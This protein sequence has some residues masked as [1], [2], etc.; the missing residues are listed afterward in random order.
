MTPSIFTVPFTTPII[1]IILMHIMT[2]MI[3]MIGIDG[4]ENDKLRF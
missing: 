3:M 2:M 4:I 1:M